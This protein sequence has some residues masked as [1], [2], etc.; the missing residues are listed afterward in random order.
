ELETNLESIAQQLLE[1]GITLHDLQ[2]ESTDVVQ[3]KLE[4]LTRTM[5]TT[6]KSSEALETLIPLELLDYLEEQ[7]GNPEAYIRDYMDHLAAENQFARGKIQAYR[8][9]SGV[10]QRQLAHAYP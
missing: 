8:S 2:P 6:Y 5:Q 9:F 7:G 10:L 1:L 4:T 3:S